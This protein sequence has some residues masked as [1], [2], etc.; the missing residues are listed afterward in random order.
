MLG[1]AAAAARLLGLDAERT[2]MALG[3]AA[4]QP[5]GVREQFGSMTKPFHL[6]RRGARGTHVGADGAS[7][8]TR[9]RRARSK[10]RAA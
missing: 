9:R 5:I 7:T 10:R 1:A 2:T 4:S 3:I 6:G 8:A